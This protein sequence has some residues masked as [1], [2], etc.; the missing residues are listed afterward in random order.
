VYAPAG[1]YTQDPKTHESI[2]TSKL[3]PRVIRDFVLKPGAPWQVELHGATVTADKPPYFSAWP[4]PDR[5]MFTTGE[6]IDTTADA[7]GKA[8]L[9][10]PPAGGHYR[11]NCGLPVFPSRY[12][13]PAANLEIDHDFDPRRITGNPERLAGRNAVRLRDEAGRAAVVEGMEVAVDAGSAVLRFQAQ[14]IP[15]A[16]ALVL[17]GVAKD[18]AGKPMTGAKCTVAFRTGRSGSMFNLAAL[19]DAQGRFELKELLLPQAIFEPDSQIRMIVVKSGY[20]GAQT[21]ELN[22][23][24]VRKSGIGDFGTVVLKPGRTLHGKVVDE[25]GQPAQGALVT[26]M[27]NYFLYSHL[28]CRTDAE[29]RFAMPDL[30]Y[31]RQKLYTAY[32][33]RYAQQTFKFDAESGECVL[34]LQLAPKSGIRP[35]VAARPR[36]APPVQVAR[37]TEGWDLTPPRKEPLYQKE[38]R[39]ALLV[40]GP[41]REQ[42][43]WMVLD[44]TT[45]YVDRNGNGDLTEP[46]KRLVPTKVKDGSNRFGEPGTYT[47]F[48][49]YDFTVRAGALGKSKLRLDHW[50]RA[51]KFVPKTEFD[52]KLDA[53]WRKLRHENGTLW[54]QDGL[55]K[56]QTAVVFMPRPADAQV[57]ALDGPLTFVGKMAEQQVLQRGEAG[58]DVAFHIAVMGRPHHGAEQQFFNPLAT[59]E[60]PDGAHLEVEIDYPAKQDHLPSVHRKYLLK[61]RC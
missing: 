28:G 8:V 48:D 43:V 37:G 4:D 32:G 39:Y 14:P 58:C 44:G 6:I 29:G 30:S 25:N 26:N 19:A 47:H 51:E 9:T 16:S 21:K 40:L 17:R 27:T 35:G 49:I 3:A 34:T 54:R 42:R 18:E 5:K 56:G 15:T 59:K 1:F 61:Q 55:G 22:L 20:D 57:C 23:L 10:I 45:L 52:K 53:Q 60:V 38:P 7:H 46:D 11:F 41:Q 31:G 33:E 50:V 36:P 13:I 24:E 12:E 2:V